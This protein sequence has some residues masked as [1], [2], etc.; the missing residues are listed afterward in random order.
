M[1]ARKR[2][3]KR[4]AAKEGAK[5]ARRRRPSKPYKFDANKREAFLDKLREGLRRGAAAEAIGVSRVTVCDAMRD[6]P[7]FADAVSQAELDSCELVEDALFKAATLDRNVTACQVYLYNRR[8]DRWRDMRQAGKAE[9]LLEALLA[10][11]PADVGRELR[12]ALGRALS[13]GAD[14]AGGAA[15]PPAAG[16]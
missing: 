15:G 12:Q 11:L 10:Q 7:D 14:Q 3:G 16:A 2:P 5:R 8:P 13:A 9:N 6:D 4:G 1:A